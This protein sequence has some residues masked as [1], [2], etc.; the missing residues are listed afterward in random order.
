MQQHSVH[1][2]HCNGS[3]IEVL[4]LKMHT[5]IQIGICKIQ[6]SLAGKLYHTSVQGILKN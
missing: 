5:K 2:K 1:L 4:Q 3:N 6:Y